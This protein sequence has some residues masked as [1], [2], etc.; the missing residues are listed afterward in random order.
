MYTPGAPPPSCP[1]SA[2]PHEKDAE[3]DAEERAK[4]LAMTNGAEAL[5]VDPPQTVVPGGPATGEVVIHVWGLP[6][7]MRDTEVAH[8]LQPMLAAADARWSLLEPPIL[9]LDRRGRN[10]GRALLRVQCDSAAAAVA[11][12]HEEQVGTRWLDARAS[13][14]A[15]LASQRQ[16][17][18]AS[19]AKLAS[20][21]QQTY[22]QPTD[23]HVAAFRMPTDCRDVVV[24]CHGVPAAVG[25]GRFEINNLREGHVDCMARCISSALFVSHGVRRATRLWLILREPRTTI[26]LDGVTAKCLSPDERSL[27]AAMKRALHAAANADRGATVDPGWAVFL[28][29]S[30]ETRMRTLANAATGLVVLHE[31]GAPLGEVLRECATPRGDSRRD[32]GDDG[33]GDGGGGGSSTGEAMDEATGEAMGEATGAARAATVLVVGDHQGF[34]KEEEALLF[35]ELNG[36][37]ARVSP[38]PLLGSQS[39]VLALAV[40]DEHAL[41]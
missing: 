35:D 18:A 24:L 7:E 13:S 27:G 15:E 31:L 29:D 4:R 23:E 40:M 37:R 28:N 22:S 17:V 39:I 38:V 9:L 26:C 14:E 33:G 2:A 20:R 36:R 21:A 3:E 34:T 6:W 16:A 41:S 19:Q 5:A 1:P 8:V 25:A 12:L 11:A 30:L 10:T 32:G